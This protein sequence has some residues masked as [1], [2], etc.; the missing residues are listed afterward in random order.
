MPRVATGAL[1]RFLADMETYE[2]MLFHQVIT[3]IL[4]RNRAPAIRSE[5]A[6]PA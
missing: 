4:K 1:G 6:E 3:N 5:L 2:A